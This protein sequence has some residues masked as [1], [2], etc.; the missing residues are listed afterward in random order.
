MVP[1]VLV[2]CLCAPTRGWSNEPTGDG[3]EPAVVDELVE[4]AD[5][6]I[7]PGDIVWEVNTRCLPES[8]TFDP[9][10][11]DVARLQECRWVADSLESVISQLN[12]RPAEEGRQAATA[13]TVIYIHGNWTDAGWPR[14]HGL[15]IY[16]ALKQLDPPPLRFLIYSWPSSR[17]R[18]E[19]IIR[20]I[21]HKSWRLDFEA[22]VLG[23]LLRRV[24]PETPVGIL[25][26]SFGAAITAGALHL[27]AGGR[28]GPYCLEGPSPVRQVHATLLASAFDRDAFRPC[29]EFSLALRQCRRIVHYY[30]SCD[31]VL[32]HF[33]WIDPQRRPEAA[34]F[35]GVMMARNASSRAPLMQ[36]SRIEQI[37]CCCC[38]GRT[39]SEVD[40]FQCLLRHPAG[41]FNL[42]DTAEP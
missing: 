9:T 31:P 24:P 37:N 38:I 7:R 25:G 42:V 14:K 5:H 28:W 8:C 4:P 13:L 19:R 30:N 3:A 41:L 18:S 26:F 36:D 27:D 40:Y 33:R 10:G 21:Q 23:N 6:L 11:I 17:D 20:D 22:F 39:H 32:K 16:C 12:M 29:G 2:A 15:R 34:G 35:S 1:V